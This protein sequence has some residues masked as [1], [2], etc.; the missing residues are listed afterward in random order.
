MSGY[1]VGS[2]RPGVTPAAMSQRGCHLP[3]EGVRAIA[4]GRGTPSRDSS[5]GTNPEVATL[6]DFQRVTGE[7]PKPQSAA[8]EDNLK[9]R[10]SRYSLGADRCAK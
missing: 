4:H 9:A 3:D 7:S 1:H 10:V 8:L 5:G 2:E 6:V